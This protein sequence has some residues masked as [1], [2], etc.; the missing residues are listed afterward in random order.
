MLLLV[1]PSRVHQAAFAL[2]TY[3]CNE[4]VVITGVGRGREVEWFAE[5]IEL[6]IVCDG[7]E[8]LLVDL[9]GATHDLGREAVLHVLRW[10]EKSASRDFEESALDINVREGAV[11]ADDNI[12]VIA[13]EKLDRV[14][15]RIINIGVLDTIPQA[16][17][18]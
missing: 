17:F 16:R 15:S 13:F 12:V 5:Q 7:G 4:A 10:V 8:A 9:C 2:L 14:G 18:S 3:F 1:W 11:S 6:I